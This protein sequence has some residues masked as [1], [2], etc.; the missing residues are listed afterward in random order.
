MRLASRTLEALPIAVAVIDRKLMLRYW[1]LHAANLLNL[2]P[3]MRDDAPSLVDALRAGGRMSQRQVGR[4][5]SYCEATIEEAASVPA[6]WLRISLGRQ[7]RVIL[8]LYP[9]GGDQWIIGFEE[10]HPIGAAL[11]SGADA[12][13]DPLTGLCNRRHFSETLHDVLSSADAGNRHAVL[14]IDLDRFQ[15]VNE[16]LGRAIGDSL[17]V[18][19]A[20]RLQRETRDD[21]VVARLG[22]DEFAI[23]QP[24]GE[25]AEALARRILEML[26]RPFMLEGHVVNI[27]ACIGIALFPEHGGSAEA[28]LKHAE[29]ALFAS[30]TAGRQ[31]WRMFQPELVRRTSSRRGLETDLR[32][33]L[34][35]GEFSVAYHPQCDAVTRRLSGFSVGPRWTNPA[36]GSVPPEVFVPLAEEIGCITD[37][38]EWLLKRA[39]ADAA[40]WQVSLSI[41]VGLS[42]VQLNEPDR[43]LKTVRAALA[44]SGLAPARLELEFP[45]NAL[46]ARE[47][48]V[49]ALMG[50]LHKLGVTLG[51][52]GFAAGWG[53]LRH[54]RTFPFDHVRIDRL[55]V[56]ALRTDSE[57]AA[58]VRAV[59]ALAADLGMI[60]LADGVDAAD[61]VAVLAEHGCKL[62][63]GALVGDE[64]D[65]PGVMSLL[66][67]SAAA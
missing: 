61:Q 15:M 65:A 40:R 12:M 11:A 19:V 66:R 59:T 41:C 44:A 3:P 14:L 17:L 48:P 43:V 37:L 18:L 36:R 58:L 64:M 50:E 25:R 23:L 24:N 5:V 39:C 67:R 20:Q 13:I 22:G 38:R 54:L 60:S 1:N 32:N 55:L 56:A 7:Q 31:N 9:L 4:I 63:E 21:D 52:S 10:P 51:I 34:P 35:L 49:I 53:A 46:A 16:T 29:V 26:A 2:P 6:T 30:K 28:L 62:L 45:G 47:G 57:T 42:A 8:K 27:G 33:A